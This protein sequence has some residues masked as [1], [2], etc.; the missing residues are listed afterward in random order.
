MTTSY[1]Y[2]V[3]PATDELEQEIEDEQGAIHAHVGVLL[4]DVDLAA[5]VLPREALNPA[6]LEEWRELWARSLAL[7]KVQEQLWQQRHELFKEWLNDGG[8]V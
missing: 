7:D 3:D 8:D 6:V 2:E 5:A 1:P 4:D